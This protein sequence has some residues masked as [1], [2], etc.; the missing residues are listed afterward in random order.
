[1]A[2]TT[3]KALLIIAAV[4][5]LLLVITGSYVFAFFNQVREPQRILLEEVVFEE[6]YNVSEEFSEHILNIGLL[7]FDR[8]WNREQSGEYLFRPDMQ[9]VVSMG[10]E[11]FMIR[12]TTPTTIISGKA[13]IITGKVFKIP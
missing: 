5:I 8:G 13:K 6:K 2:G 9:A 12:S 3:K 4:L 1:M 10:L 7:G 11:D